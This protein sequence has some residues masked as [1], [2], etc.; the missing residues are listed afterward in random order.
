MHHARFLYDMFIPFTPIMSALSASS[1][2]YKGKL[3]DHDLRFEVIEQSVDCRTPQERDKSS[4]E[5]LPKSRY[6]PVSHYISNHE[7]VRH[8]HNDTKRLPV[9]LN[10]MQIL[11]EAGVDERLAYHVASLFI[12]APIPAYEKEF[13]FP[14][15]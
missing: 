12:R 13:M 6:S 2:L 8:F 10:A 15:E 3:G 1:P 5:Y 7:Y 9:C 14:G 4:E 11:T